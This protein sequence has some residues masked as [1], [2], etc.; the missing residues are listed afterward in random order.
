MG[1]A[2][3]AFLPPERLEATLGRVAFGR[4]GPNALTTRRA[5]A[6][7]L[8]RIRQTG[9]SISDEEL[10]HGLRS[11]AAPVLHRSGYAAINLAVHRSGAPMAELSDRFGPVLRRTAERIST[12]IG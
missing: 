3:L 2:L 6:A 1:K 8:R 11:I 7:E 12:I 9:I 10:G 5:L 4:H